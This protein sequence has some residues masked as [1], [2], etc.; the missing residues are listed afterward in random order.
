MCVYIPIYTLFIPAPDGRL[1][2]NSVK[3]LQAMI[4]DEQIVFSN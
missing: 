1:K 2:K 3:N 4:Q